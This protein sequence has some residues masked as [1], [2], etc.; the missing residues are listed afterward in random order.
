[1]TAAIYALN[2]NDTC[3]EGTSLSKQ[4]ITEAEYWEKYYNY[5]DVN[6]EWNNGELEEKE[7][8]EHITYLTHNWFVELLGY[9]L[10]TYS[11]AQITGLEMG[12]RLVLPQKVNLST[13]AQI[14]GYLWSSMLQL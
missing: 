8:S 12:F 14:I 1:M 9:Y 4:Y 10:K 7:V 3:S 13:E 2:Y 5:P 6:Y 11:I